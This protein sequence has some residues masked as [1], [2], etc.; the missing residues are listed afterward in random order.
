M[1]YCSPAI[2]N[3][4]FIT[5][6]IA[7]A[8]LFSQSGGSVFAAICPHL[9]AA[10]NTCHEM[11]QASNADH[12][13]ATHSEGDVFE[14]D[15]TAASCNHCAVHSRTRRDD[16]ALQETSVIQRANDLTVAAAS[17]TVSPVFF[18]TNI[19]PVVRAHGPPGATAPLHILLNVFRI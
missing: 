4:R 10:N 3:R 11:A 6:I 9:R 8:V 12:H 16:S 5:G 2:M 7:L 15:E 13:Q 17:S 19:T 18:S 1:L 14:T